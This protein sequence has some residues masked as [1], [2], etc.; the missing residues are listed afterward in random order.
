VNKLYRSANGKQVDFGSILLKNESVIAVGNMKV[1]ARG[2][3]LGPG[4]KVVKTRDQIMKEYY[5]LNTPVAVDE[6]R[7]QVQRQQVENNIPSHTGV[8]RDNPLPTRPVVQQPTPAPMPPQAPPEPIVVSENSGLDDESDMETEVTT[9]PTVQQQPTP[10]TAPQPAV[11]NMNAPVQSIT[12]PSP[13]Q[14]QTIR[15]PMRG[16]LAGSV[17][18]AAT[19]TQTEKLPLKKANGIQRF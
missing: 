14:Q 16:S 6:L 18:K 11:Q 2:D 9:A 19:V 15:Q 8:A 17:A 12:R 13:A 7:D 4:G 1:N 3:Q 5:A 10:T